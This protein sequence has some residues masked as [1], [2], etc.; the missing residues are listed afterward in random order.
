[1]EHIKKMK[2]EV[3]HA[4][5]NE[6]G[7]VKFVKQQQKRNDQE[8]QDANYIELNKV[9]MQWWPELQQLRTKVQSNIKSDNIKKALVKKNELEEKQR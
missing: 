9:F 7:Q 6:V 4:V 5:A 2:S 8:Q 1:M 3:T